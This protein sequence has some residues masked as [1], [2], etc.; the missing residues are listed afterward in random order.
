MCVVCVGCR[1][2][3]GVRVEATQRNT[4]ESIQCRVRGI[5][6]GGAVAVYSASS[7]QKKTRGE[8]EKP[9]LLGWKTKIPKIWNPAIVLLLGTNDLETMIQ[10]TKDGE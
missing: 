9:S 2:V 7:A 6:D 5:Q 10:N 1:Y 3:S 8:R 4:C